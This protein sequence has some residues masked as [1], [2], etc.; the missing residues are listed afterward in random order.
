MTFGEGNTQRT[1]LITFDVVDIAYTYNAIFGRYSIIIFAAVINQ[2]YLCMKIP[3]ARGVITILGNQEEARRCEDNAACAMKNVHAIEAANNE[4]EQEEAKPPCFE[5]PH[6]DGVFPVE[7]TKKAPLCE[8]VPDRIVT[9]SKGLEKI[10]E[11]RLIQFLRNNQ[12]VFAWSSSDLRGVSQEVM[13]L[14]LRVAPKVKPWKQRLRTMTEDRK[15]AAQSEVQKLLNAGV[16][17]EVQ[18]PE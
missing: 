15:K 17:C 4:E 18:Y 5:Q 10:E 8:D 1:E 6:K 16:I 13:E 7:H 12:D 9:I 3:T 14:E 11:A 2:A